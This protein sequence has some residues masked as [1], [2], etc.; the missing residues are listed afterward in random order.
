MLTADVWGN[1]EELQEGGSGQQ[2]RN[3]VAGTRHIGR[4]EQEKGNEGK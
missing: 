2:C 3:A 4:A 1:T